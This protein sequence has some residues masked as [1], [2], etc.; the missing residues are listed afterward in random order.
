MPAIDV[1]DS[2]MF[3]EET[4]TGMPLVFLRGNPSSWYL[5]RHVLPR[6]GEPGRCLAPDL[7]GMGGSGKPDVPYRY[8]DHARYL[9]AWFDELAL[10]GVVLIG[11]DWGGALAFDWA[12]RHPGRTRGVAFMETIV[13]PM[14][15]D[16]FP[17]GARSR[18]E[19]FRTPG[20]G[21]TMVL[22]ENVFIEQTLRMTVL[23]GLSDED[24]EAYRKPYPTRDSRRPLLEWP[25]D[26][27]RRRASRRGR[28][29]RG[30]R[31]LARQ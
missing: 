28:P 15:W 25:R 22:D 8:A 10:D 29:N 1:L 23:T 18:F 9:D 14:S 17:A 19:S 30:V 11:H 2:T 16:E 12:T 7:I 6:I 3:C 21:E 26:A 31:R 13:R 24:L 20:V 27:A 4:G 5:W